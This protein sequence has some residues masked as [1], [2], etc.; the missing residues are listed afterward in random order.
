MNNMPP[1]QLPEP[2]SRAE[3]AA[4]AVPAAKAPP[5]RHRAPRVVA[6]LVLL[7]AL[8]AGAVAWWQP[9]RARALLGL[10]PRAADR[11]SVV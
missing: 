7:V 10:A 9:D 4:P 6:A 2:R 1:A 5:A 8:A 3:T 11:K